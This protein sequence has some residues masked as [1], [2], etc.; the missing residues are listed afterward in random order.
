MKVVG[1]IAEYNPF[2]EGHRYHI[3]A[4]RRVSGADKVVVI[5]SGSFVQRGE[6]ACADKFIRAKWAVDNGADMVIELPD[7][8]ALSC[9]E[10]FAS[11]AVRILNGTGMVDSICFGSESGDINRILEL[12]E[13]GEDCEKLAEALASGDP[14]PK[15]AAKASGS[16]L[17]PNDILAVEYARA[18]KRY[19]PGMELFAI[20]REGSAYDDDKLDYEYSSAK[21]IRKAF[22]NC[23]ASARMSPAVFDSLSRA[24]PREVLEDISNEIRNGAFPSVDAN[25][26]DAIMYRFRSMSVDE[27]ACLPEVA[28]GLENLFKKH[29]S[30]SSYEELLAAVKSKRY[31]MARLKRI[32]MC[33]LLGIDK[34]L[35]DAA[36]SDDNA[37]YA[38]VLAVKEDSRELL[39][40]LSERSTIP[41][42]IR[43]AD[44]E[45]LTE[46]AA[47]I[48]AVSAFAHSVRALGQ[49]YDKSFLEDGG[50][51]LIVR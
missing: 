17:P 2:H 43:G 20:K 25:L 21:A 40:N 14:Y 15:A 6:P 48:E 23:G 31:T 41:V 3:E 36:A 29:S 26:S 39:T 28:E 10:R 11:G 32:S 19:A 1:I 5:M 16:P 33:A 18:V 50:Y 44:R 8:F 35:Q 49:P 27:I 45:K 30:L 12:A 13:R 42:V 38:R 24:L 46:T 7:V 9:A 37:L 4:A 47:R 22:I 34:K 51:R